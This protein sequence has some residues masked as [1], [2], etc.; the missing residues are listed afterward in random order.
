MKTST[1]SA[2][3][4]AQHTANIWVSEVANELGDAADKHRAYHALRA[5]LHALR[6][7][8]PVEEAADLSAQLPMLVRG[9]YFDG[10][11]PAH[12]PLRERS[13]EQFLGHVASAFPAE[14]CPNSE[15][16]TRAVFKVLQHHVAAGEIA[17]VKATLPEEVR[18]LWPQHAQ[19]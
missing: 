6:D 4:N 16:I 5:V 14:I 17:D 3:E 15:F 8:L 10:W 7:R 9:F 12:K 1:L 11:R 19:V 18:Q 13:R 2:F